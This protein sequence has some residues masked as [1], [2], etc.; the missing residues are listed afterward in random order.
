MTAYADRSSFFQGFRIALVS[1]AI[2]SG[3][4]GAR[5]G[6][7]A[8]KAAE[9][10][11][12]LRS[13]QT[14]GA[15]AA[16]DSA[17]DAFWAAAPLT[18]ANAYFTTADSGEASIPAPAAGPFVTGEPVS[19][20]LQP[21]GYGFSESKGTFRIALTTGIEIRTPGGIIIAKTDDFGR[22]EW[23]GPVKNRSFTGRINIALPS[24]PSGDYQIVLTLTDQTSPKS[25]SVTLPFEIAAE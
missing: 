20:Y 8:Y 7:I 17:I 12:L 3:V 13:G 2:L 14:E 22:L 6:E 19:I 9:A 4:I 21:L 10:E 18:L 23:A 16:L 5:A 15:F 11:T 25:A 24:L 1:I